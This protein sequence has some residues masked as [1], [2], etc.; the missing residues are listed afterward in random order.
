MPV[1]KATLY[2][3]MDIGFYKADKVGFQKGTNLP[4][5]PNS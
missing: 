3:A 4:H 5:I 2:T 1:P